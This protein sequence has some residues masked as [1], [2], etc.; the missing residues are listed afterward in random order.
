[1]MSTCIPCDQQAK[2]EKLKKLRI[3]A[4]AWAKE[5]GFKE[6]V[7]VKAPNG[8]IYYCGP[9]DERIKR[10]TVIEFIPLMP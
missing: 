4:T 10:L 6:A 5:K 8:F 9:D 3:D 7:L 1:M 2:E